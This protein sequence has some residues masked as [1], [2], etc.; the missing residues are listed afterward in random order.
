VW[1]AVQGSAV[2]MLSEGGGLGRWEASLDLDCDELQSAAHHGLLIW[3]GVEAPIQGDV[4]TCTAEEPQNSA[5]HRTEWSP[6]PERH[7]LRQQ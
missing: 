1:G 3:V 7:S 6:L 2:S 4:H 5:G